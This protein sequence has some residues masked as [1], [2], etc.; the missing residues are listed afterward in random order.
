M[1][2]TTINEL[3]KIRTELFEDVISKFN[4]KLE[5]LVLSKSQIEITLFFDKE[6]NVERAVIQ[7]TNNY[8]EETIGANL[9]SEL[10]RRIKTAGYDID[11]E[12][13]GKE[14]VV[15]V[16]WKKLAKELK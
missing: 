16:S 3:G 14:T 11:H 8:D 12:K 13:R 4:S 2:I 9:Y 15:I 7:S 10:F 6:N 5:D 1:E